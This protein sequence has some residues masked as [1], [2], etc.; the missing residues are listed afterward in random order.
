MTTLTIS[1]A[2]WEMLEN[3][4]ANDVSFSNLSST[5][6]TLSMSL[7]SKTA[8]F[9]ISGLFSNPTGLSVEA[10][11][12]SVSG[13]VSGIALTI[14]G[15]KQFAASG[16]TLDASE[17][18]DE[19]VDKIHDIVEMALG[20]EVDIEG[21]EDDDDVSGSGGDDS[22]H[23]RG[24]DDNLSG[25][26]GDDSMNGGIGD[27]SLSGGSG[28]DSLYGD[29]GND[30]LRGG[31]GDDSLYGGLG[32]DVYYVDSDL[33]RISETGGGGRD[34]E[35]SSVSESGLA[36]GVERLVLTGSA[37]RG[38][39]NGGNNTL[40]GNTANNTLNGGAGDD[41]LIGGRGH[42]RLNGGT[43]DDIFDFNNL[44]EL[45]HGSGYRDSISGFVRGDDRIDL[46]TI[47][48]HASLAG[49]QAFRFVS[50]FSSNATGE[51]RY[52]DGVVYISTDADRSSEFEIELIGTPPARLSI[53]D[54]IL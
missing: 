10:W 19:A 40:I 50:S 47:D 39:G 11:L 1:H 29:S 51:I 30:S 22:M 7:G 32:D 24:G 35:Y 4:T 38:T 9:T 48:A 46:S 16:L 15:V 49:N 42:D 23:G 54:F 2:D 41:R 12:A 27:D 6:A 26:L 21:S 5:Q 3:L 33:D 45:G 34:T 18:F 44:L 8:V 25:E 37:L 13:S 28:R 36:S 17:V 52:T 31:S 53:S 20:E 43:G 14:D